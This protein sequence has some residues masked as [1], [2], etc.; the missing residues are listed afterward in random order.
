MVRDVVL[1]QK[2]IMENV[3]KHKSVYIFFDES[4]TLPDPKDT[5][6]IVAAVGTAQPQQL[7]RVTSQ[8]RNHLTKDKNRL[9]EIKFYNAGDKTRFTFLKE[10]VEK[11]IRI[12]TLTIEKPGQSIP[13]TPENFALLCWLLLEECFLF[14]GQGIHEI[15]FDKH[16]HKKTDREVFDARLVELTGRR[17]SIIHAD[18][19]NDTRVNTA[20]MVAGSIL[21]FRTGKNKQFYEVIKEKIISEK[22][23]H[24][25][26]AK[27]GLFRFGK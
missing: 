8:T 10:L 6:V 15:I 20:D 1:F 18:S 22:V 19:V 24:W 21:Y 4:G 9:S 12:F 13:D 27:K 3:A 17:F 25:K 5:V 26:E 7:I 11:D 23:L 14:Y 2:H 16:F